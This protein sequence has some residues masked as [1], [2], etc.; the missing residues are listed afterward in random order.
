M[1]MDDLIYTSNDVDMIY[2]FQHSIKER[3]DMIDLDMMKYYLGI[4]VD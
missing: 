4:K 3:F 2:E 1:Y